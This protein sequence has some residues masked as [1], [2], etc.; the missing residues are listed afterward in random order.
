MPKVVDA[1]AQRRDI[2]SAA[3]RV[4]SQHGVAG[5]GLAHVAE[6][7]GMGRSSLY[8]YYPDKASLLRDLV[9]DLLAEEEAVFRE[10]LRGEGDALDRIERLM[11]VLA[12][13]F[14]AWTHAGRMISDLRVRDARMFRPFFRRVRRELAATITEGQASGVIDRDVDAELAA[15][16]LIGA[17]DG[18]LLQRIVDP[19]AFEPPARL[20]DELVRLTR[21]SLER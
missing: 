21:R 11:T 4:F 19:R 9:R 16:T 17:V 5:T 15:A 14:E 10:A 18:L 3:R 6:A 7:A 1:P 12:G 2:R 20:R 8:H 13:M